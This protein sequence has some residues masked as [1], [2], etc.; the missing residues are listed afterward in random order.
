MTLLSA[1]DTDMIDG[2]EGNAGCRDA[3]FVLAVAGIDRRGQA[4]ADRRD[5]PP[6]SILINSNDSLG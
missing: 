3:Q 4:F 1:E 5:T 6:H 2:A